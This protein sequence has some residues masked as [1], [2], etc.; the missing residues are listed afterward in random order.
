MKRPDSDSGDTGE[1]VYDSKDATRDPARCPSARAAPGGSR[2]GTASPK[3][4]RDPRLRPRRSRS[5]DVIWARIV[6]GGIARI[7]LRRILSRWARIVRGG[8][9]CVAVGSHYAS[10]PRV[11]ASPG[12]D[13]PG[14]SGRRRHVR[15]EIG[16]GPDP[17]HRGRILITT[18][19]TRRR[20]GPVRRG[21]EALPHGRRGDQQG[22]GR[23][24]KRVVLRERT[25][26]LPVFRERAGFQSNAQVGGEARSTGNLRVRGVGRPEAA[27][28]GRRRL[29]RD[30]EA[31]KTRTRRTP[32][33]LTRSHGQK[34]P[35]LLW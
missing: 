3:G 12:L 27:E 34:G 31:H 9:D 22:R 17:R 25:R 7:A 24:V 11:H 19:R 29:P 15:P 1:R 16:S 4:G 2:F 10:R 6:R 30:G 18:A 13:R 20:A 35:G 32:K 21:T 14:L 28:G 8:A 26:D 5:G 23:A 33:P